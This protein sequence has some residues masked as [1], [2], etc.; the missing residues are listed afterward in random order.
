MSTMVAF[1][2]ITKRFGKLRALNDISFEVK[3]GEVLG[4][5]GP[6]G[7]GKTTAMRILTGYFPPTEGCIYFDG[8]KVDAE[9]IAFKRR[10]GYLPEMVPLYHDLKVFDFLKF[11]AKIRGVKRRQLSE[12]VPESIRTAARRGHIPHR[13]DAGI[14]AALGLPFRSGCLSYPKENQNQKTR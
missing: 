1:D 3:K 11:V 4:F 13:R 14:N 10:I 9:E 12:G 7:A 6:N 5:L 2:H 8:K